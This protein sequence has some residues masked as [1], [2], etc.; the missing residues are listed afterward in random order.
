MSLICLGSK[1]I[2]EDKVSYYKALTQEK[3]T[4]NPSP[5]FDDDSMEMEVSTGIEK[6]VQEHDDC[7]SEDTN[8]QRQGEVDFKLE[9]ANQRLRNLANDPQ[10]SKK[11][12]LSYL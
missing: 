3:E 12:L 8:S 2:H 6:A 9:M 10:V 1:Y 4:C 11:I 5:L 7:H